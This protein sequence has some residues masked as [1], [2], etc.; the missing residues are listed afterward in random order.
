MPSAIAFR[1]DAKFARTRDIPRRV[2]GERAD[3]KVFDTDSSRS[4]DASRAD[5]DAGSAG[6]FAGV[7]ANSNSDSGS[8]LNAAGGCQCHGSRRGCVRAQRVAALR[9][10][11]S[12]QDRHRLPPRA[13]GLGADS[14]VASDDRNGRRVYGDKPLIVVFRVDSG[15]ACSFDP[16]GHVDCDG[17]RAVFSCV[18]PRGT[19]DSHRA[20]GH[21][22]FAQE[23][24]GSGASHDRSSGR[25]LYPPRRDNF[26]LSGCGRSRI[27]RLTRLRG[28]YS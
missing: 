28:R 20:Y 25:A 8:A 23:A 19:L 6:N 1:V 15:A 24:D 13:R 10:D 27:Y 2:D 12:G 4:G 21:I 22:R 7:R 11:L 26:Q 3:A 17:A 16:S 18:Y 9:G 5:R 14:L